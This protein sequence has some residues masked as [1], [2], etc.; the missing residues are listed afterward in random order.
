MFVLTID[1]KG[2]RVVGDKV[3]TL[4][5]QLKVALGRDL[6]PIIPFARTVGDEIQGVVDNPASVYATFRT[7]MEH[8]GWYMGVGV[9]AVDTPLPKH[10]VE[11]SGT[12]FIH[13]RTAVE[14]AK[15][16]RGGTPVSVVGGSAVRAGEAQGLLRLLGN[17]LSARSMLMWE[18]VNALS[19]PDG[20]LTGYT[21]KDVA[22]KLGVS[23][24]AVSKR[25]KAAA[26][27]AELEVIPLLMR[28]LDESN[29]G[30]AE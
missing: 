27:D 17:T 4:L 26:F 7:I 23:S 21:Q 1:Q 19:Y 10:T 25:V 14:D 28:L 11:G 13:A 6:A 29:E 3:P 16:S 15:I 12:A 18:A 20:R 9:G 2:S 24:A 22:Q 8:Q 5:R 30:V